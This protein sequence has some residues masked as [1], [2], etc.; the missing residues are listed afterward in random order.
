[1]AGL[2]LL[3]GAKPASNSARLSPAPAVVRRVLG[4]PIGA[5]LV[6]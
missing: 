6:R 1:M 5:N 4:N 2:A 3:R